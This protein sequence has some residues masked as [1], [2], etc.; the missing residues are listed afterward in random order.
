MSD[1][2]ESRWPGRISFNGDEMAAPTEWV[3]TLLGS[4]GENKRQQ[5]ALTCADG[6]RLLL[7]SRQ[8]H[9]VG[10]MAQLFRCI[11][12]FGMQSQWPVVLFGVCTSRSTKI[13]N[14]L[15]AARQHLT[16]TNGSLSKFESS[17]SSGRHFS[18]SSLIAQRFFLFDSENV[19]VSDSNASHLLVDRPKKNF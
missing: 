4:A 19:A 16:K 7:V 14:S 10:K 3:L 15:H 6:F 17:P 2:P 12:V 11:C 13:L 8:G 5:R 18:I 1:D 9:E